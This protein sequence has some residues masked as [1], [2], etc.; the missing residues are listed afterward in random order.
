MRDG[1]ESNSATA[2]LA[3]SSLDWNRLAGTS[4]SG[5]E[6]LIGALSPPSS[7]PRSVSAKRFVLPS[8]GPISRG[9]FH[10]GKLAEVDLLRV[11]LQAAQIHAG[12]SNAEL[13]EQ[14]AQLELAREMGVSAAGP[15][16]LTEKFDELESP[17]QPDVEN[18]TSDPHYALPIRCSDRASSGKTPERAKRPT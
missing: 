9:A 13:E 2:D 15:W 16:T 5:Y 1:P 3:C 12:F 18:G 7:A 6:T 14:K 8:G 10:E 11:Q 17:R 4:D